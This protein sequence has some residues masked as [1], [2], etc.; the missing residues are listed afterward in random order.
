MTNEDSKEQTGEDE[1]ETPLVLLAKLGDLGRFVPEAMLKAY[2]S[3]PVWFVL[4][5]DQELIELFERVP[6]DPMQKGHT[7]AIL[8]AL[9]AFAEHHNEPLQAILGVT[10]EIAYGFHTDATYE[11]VRDS[12]EEDG[13]DAL[14]QVIADGQISDLAAED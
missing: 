7:T 8:G 9:R 14:E 11:R 3:R 13:F 1:D 4:G 5:M 6:E 10:D 12:F 2:K